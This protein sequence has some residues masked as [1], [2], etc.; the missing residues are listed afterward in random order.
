MTEQETAKQD[1]TRYL[2]EERFDDFKQAD[3][4]QLPSH[5]VIQFTAQIPNDP[6]HPR[7]GIT[8]QTGISQFDS[9]E[10]AINHN[11]TLDPKNFEI[12]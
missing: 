12:K 7:L 6:D 9:T 3:G 11:I 8:D 4:L 10:T 5:W 1:F 2:L